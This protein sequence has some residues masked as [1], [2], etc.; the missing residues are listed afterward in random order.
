MAI[1]RSEKDAVRASRRLCQRGHEVIARR[2]SP[3]GVLPRGWTEASG[4]ERNR[5]ERAD[6][7][8]ASFGNVTSVQDG[9]G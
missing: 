9:S 4:H 3:D 8:I 2:R 7:Q 6:A 1:G 5:N